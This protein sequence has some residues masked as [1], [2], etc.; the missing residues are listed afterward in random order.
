MKKYIHCLPV[1]L[2][3][4]STLPLHMFAEPAVE[5]RQRE[6]SLDRGHLAAKGYD[7]VSYH[8][9]NGP[10]KG[11]KSI[12]AEFRGVIYRFESQANKAEFLKDP[13]KYEP[14]Y[15]GWC[16]WAMLDGDRTEPNP[17]SYKI[18]D[19]KLYL[20][21]DG[22]FGDTLKAWNKKAAETSDEALIKQADVRWAQQV[23]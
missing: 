21:Y 11:K 5:V 20:F 22:F 3:V 1:L 18:V 17:K 2:T 9:L 15:G 13:T 16:A 23:N 8:L 4:L 19:G 14:E 6:Y 10:I 7:P 12:A